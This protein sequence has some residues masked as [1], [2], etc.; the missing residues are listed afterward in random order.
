MGRS[1]RKMNKEDETK[2]VHEKKERETRKSEME[3]SDGP[4]RETRDRRLDRLF[5]KI[6]T[7]EE[8]TILCGRLF[9]A[10]YS[11]LA[12]FK[13]SAQYCISCSFL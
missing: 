10:Y 8:V 5:L 11:V 4:K 13:V 3:S 7:E 12:V 6:K 1:L 9:Q 2:K